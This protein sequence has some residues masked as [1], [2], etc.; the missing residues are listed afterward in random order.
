MR[1]CSIQSLVLHSGNNHKQNRHHVICGL[2]C[3]DDQNFRKIVM[4]KEINRLTLCGCQVRMLI[5]ENFFQH[6]LC[7]YSPGDGHLRKYDV[8]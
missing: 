6:Q 4:I 2:A 5:K 1:S 3:G 7:L 8:M